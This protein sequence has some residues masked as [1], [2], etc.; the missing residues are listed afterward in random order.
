LREVKAVEERLFIAR[1]RR[2]RPLTD[3]KILADWNGMVIAGLAVAGRVLGDASLVER[4][5]A[6]ARFVLARMRSPEGVLLHSWRQGQGRIPAYLDDYAFLVR[7]L[8]ALHEAQG[9]GFWLSTAVE[10]T[11]EQI[12]RLRDPEGGF[13]VAAESPDLLFRSKDVFDGATPAGNAVAVLNLLDLAAR[14]DERAWRSEARAS[15]QAFAAMIQGSPEGARMMSIAARRYHRAEM[16][17]GDAPLGEVT[18]VAA[19]E[20][21]AEASG[22]EK[23]ARAAAGLVTIRLAE[24]SQ[25]AG[26]QPFRLVVEVSPGWHIQANPASEEFL[27]PTEVAAEGGAEVRNLQYPQGEEIPAGFA[28]GRPLAVYTGRVE[29][30]GEVSGHG[31]LA[32]RFQLCDDTRCLPPAEQT[33]EV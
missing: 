14:T 26:W 27:L 2:D 18:E 28:D 11:K 24:H 12:S 31:R 21:T 29:V 8:L 13:F 5:A 15:L 7:G 23:L 9:D 25:E 4:A 3:D 19:F 1:A 6:A 16:G 30:T 17:T 32:V 10:L 33:V 22:V 20:R